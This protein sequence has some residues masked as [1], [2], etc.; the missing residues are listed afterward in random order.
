MGVFIDLLEKQKKRETQRTVDLPARGKNLK[1][2]TLKGLEDQADDLYN[3]V[4]TLLP[5]NIDL[6]RIGVQLHTYGEARPSTKIRFMAQISETNHRTYL[7]KVHCHEVNPRGNWRKLAKAE[8]HY[9][10]RRSPA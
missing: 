5:N 10:E 7:V 1:W 4:S 3:Q 9:R 6:K 8:Y 2:V